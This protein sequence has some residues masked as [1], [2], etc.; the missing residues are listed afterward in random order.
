ME[1]I[2]ILEL[3]EVGVLE[4]DD[5]ERAITIKFTP[6]ILKLLQFSCQ[7]QCS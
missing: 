2:N 1:Y 5:I 7:S 3:V 6:V 4:E